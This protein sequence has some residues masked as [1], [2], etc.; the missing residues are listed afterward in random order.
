MRYANIDLDNSKVY[1]FIIWPARFKTALA[2][3]KIAALLF[4]VLRHGR[5]AV[6]MESFDSL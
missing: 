5:R 2:T 1:L 6:G 3:R 4:Q